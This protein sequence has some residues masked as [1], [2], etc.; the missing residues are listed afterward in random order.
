MFAQGF[1]QF[2]QVDPC[3]S[4]PCQNS[5]ACFADDTPG[6]T[7]KCAEGFVGT[8]CEQVT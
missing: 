7:C 3:G 4:S 6:F 2:Q 5:G 1:S 8:L